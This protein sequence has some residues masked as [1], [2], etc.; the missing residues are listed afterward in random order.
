M[1]SVSVS[2]FCN[3][4][5]RVRK[6]RCDPPRAAGVSVRI[7]DLDSISP[8][9]VQRCW[10]APAPRKGGSLPSKIIMRT[11]DSV[12]RCSARSGPKALRCISLR[13]T[14]SYTAAIRTNSSTTLASERDRLSKQWDKSQNKPSC[15]ALSHEFDGIA[16]L[17]ILSGSVR[18]RLLQELTEARYGSG[19]SWRNISPAMIPHSVRN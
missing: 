14:R 11:V 7:V 3:R 4:S 9:T 13:F 19:C 8:S 1:I 12:M 6:V 2:S 18:Q 17:N 15:I 5:Y 16:F 10:T